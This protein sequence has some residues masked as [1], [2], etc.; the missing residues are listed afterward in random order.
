V[1]KREEIKQAREAVARAAATREALRGRFSDDRDE[2]LQAALDDLSAAMAPL[3]AR[4][5]RAPSVGRADFLPDVRRVSAQVQA[6][7]RRVYRM[8]KQVPGGP[9]KPS[10]PPV[11]SWASFRGKVFAAETKAKE[12]EAVMED[13]RQY[14]TPGTPDYREQG[15]EWL[16]RIDDVR[17]YLRDARRT[18]RLQ[19]F[20]STA[21][22]RRVVDRATA[23]ADLL[24][25]LRKRAKRMA[26]SPQKWPS[27]PPKRTKR[28]WIAWTADDALAALHGFEYEHGRY[29]TA[30]EL[31]QHPE[32]P[33]WGTIRSLLG[34]MPKN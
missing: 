28:K 16:E 17:A 31:P 30:R 12:I 19:N 5:L 26:D 22:R 18:A 6:E 7:R 24:D 1:T 21:T 32:L 3:R 14:L 33:S 25:N 34:G 15:R 23:T 9:S 20:K 4:L 11:M 13:Q 27:R 10:A 29:P 8:L 2:R